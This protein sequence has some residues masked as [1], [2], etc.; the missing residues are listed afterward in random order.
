[1]LLREELGHRASQH[2]FA[3]ARLADH[4]DV[5]TLLSRLTNDDRGG[6][7]ANH[8]IDQFLRNRNLFGRDDV[9]VLHPMLD[10]CLADR[11]LVLG[12]AKGDP[13]FPRL[14]RV[15]RLRLIAHAASPREYACHL[16][17]LEGA[18]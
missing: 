12:D 10:R 13:V 7:L 4:D 17:L 6:L 3:G 2:R 9:D 15:D 11:I 1:M 8:L 5:S 14:K 16:H 18:S